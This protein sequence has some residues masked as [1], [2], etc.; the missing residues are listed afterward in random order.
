MLDF[1]M[2]TDTSAAAALHAQIFGESGRGVR[3]FYTPGVEREIH[4]V[5]DGDALV[6]VLSFFSVSVNG[7]PC[8]YMAGVCTHPDYRGRGLFRRNFAKAKETSRYDVR[9]LFCIPAND[10]LFGLYESVGLRKRTCASLLPLVGDGC[11]GKAFDGDYGRLFALYCASKPDVQH[12]FPLFRACVDNFL[13]SGRAFYAGDGFALTDR[14]GVRFACGANPDE[15]RGLLRGRFELL[16]R[17][18]QGRE[19][20][21]AAYCGDRI[22]E[23]TYINLL[24][25]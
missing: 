20:Y 24:F 11:G 1:A 25:N 5:F 14:T 22:Q 19:V 12:N 16:T 10:S 7:A 23:D 21:L 3:A 6:S 9:N 8:V 15:L 18:G 13:A 4:G 17:A 2:L